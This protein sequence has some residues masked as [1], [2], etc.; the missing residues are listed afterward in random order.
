MGCNFTK[1]LPQGEETP[2]EKLV[3]NIVPRASL[4]QPLSPVHFKTVNRLRLLLLPQGKNSAADIRL[5]SARK[6]VAYIDS[7]GRM[8]R[9]QQLEKE[10]PE[11]F[12]DESTLRGMLPEL[13]S[14]RFATAPEKTLLTDPGMCIFSPMCVLSY[15]WV[16]ID[17]PDPDGAQLQQLRPVLVWYL[18]ERARRK[19]GLQAPVNNRD[20][21]T[22]PDPMI[23]TAD[24]GVFIDFMSMH[25]PDQHGKRTPEEQASFGRALSNI[26]LLYGH[27]DTTVMKITDTPTVNDPD[28]VYSRRGWTHLERRLADLDG[29]AH[30]CIDVS[31]WNE[32]VKARCTMLNE[33]H[34][35]GFSLNE[36]QVWAPS[37][38]QR[39]VPQLKSSDQ[40]LAR[41][42]DYCRQYEPGTIAVL[43]AGPNG[44]GSL[45]SPAA[46]AEELKL[47]V[48][49]YD[50]DRKV[51]EGLYRGVAEPV[52]AAVEKLAFTQIA[53]ADE[54]FLN[55]AGVLDCTAKLASLSFDRMGEDHGR[56][57]LQEKK[58]TTMGLD[59]RTAQLVFGKLARGSLL[60]L[61]MVSINVCSFGSEGLRHFADALRRGAAQNLKSFSVDCCFVEEKGL[62]HLGECL[63]Q[64]GAPELETLYFSFNS[65]PNEGANLGDKGVC[66]L[67]DSFMKGGAPKLKSLSIHE[68]I[69]DQAAMKMA[70]TLASGRALLK[71]ETLKLTGPHFKAFALQGPRITDIGAEHLGKALS[72]PGAAPS[73][74]ELYLD[75]NQVSSTGAQAML[76]A[77]QHGS[78]AP[79]LKK[80]EFYQGRD[81]EEGV[82]GYK[83]KVNSVSGEDQKALREFLHGRAP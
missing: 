21:H 32:A 58:M 7:G 31:R 80:I 82:H 61:E 75:Q 79:S 33:R 49:G 44:R 71:L 14:T 16:S 64:G 42:G 43:N 38:E 24:F 12:V 53:W 56:D 50:S 68:P 65:N 47:R 45:V 37:S 28:R 27:T 83:A 62:L 15:A 39:A 57:G 13:E 3:A 59:D 22:K 23:K 5:V 78:G 70:E 8:L 73:L 63:A 54:D 77:L 51:C 29:P 48:F 74:V 20:K 6:L 72:Q 2:N 25:Q 4:D 1:I 76:K 81:T 10:Q 46:F 35:Y 9:R 40:E 69:T 60:G 30:K 11:L 34:A 55:L 52:L 36:A 26:G 18:C 67:A 19:V 17:D 66:H 41:Q